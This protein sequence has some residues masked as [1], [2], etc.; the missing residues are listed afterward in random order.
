MCKQYHYHSG[1]P[2]PDCD[3]I[4]GS[5][6]RN[7][8]CPEALK[9]RRLGRCSVG[10]HIAGNFR[11]VDSTTR[12]DTCKQAAPTLQQQQQQQHQAPEKGIDDPTPRP[13][14]APQTNG[15][16][17]GNDLFSIVFERALADI[18]AAQK[19]SVGEKD[20]AES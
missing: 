4:L 19:S 15:N 10:V 12:C 20:K 14:A 9:A 13:E 2:T 18:Q 16:K 6:K 8:Y 11:A 3:S 7:R 1:C 5:R 17:N